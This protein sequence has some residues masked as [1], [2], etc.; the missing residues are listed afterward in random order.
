MYGEKKLIVKSYTQRTGVR[1]ES[2]RM[3]LSTEL[4]K[5]LGDDMEDAKFLEQC[6]I[7]FDP[8]WLVDLKDLDSL[9]DEKPVMEQEPPSEEAANYVRDLVRIANI[10]A[11]VQFP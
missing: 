2:D 11:R 8:E 10:L 6:G 7:S 9:M 5:S 4:G 3:N 1:E